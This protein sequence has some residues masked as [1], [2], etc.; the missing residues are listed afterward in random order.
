MDMASESSQKNLHKKLKDLEKKLRESDSKFIRLYE[1]YAKQLASEQQFRMLSAH[2]EQEKKEYT[3][4]IEKLNTM[5]D[6]LEDSACK[7]KQLTDEMAECAET[8]ELTTAIVN[9]LIEK[10]EVSEPQI[11]DGEKVQN[12]RIFYKFVGEIN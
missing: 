5:A 2:F 1:D 7:A 4:E 11:T 3:V 8:K 12:L 9:R 10:L 6:N